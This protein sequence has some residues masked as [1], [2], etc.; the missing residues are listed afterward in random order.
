MK[1]NKKKSKE[2]LVDREIIKGP[3]FRI[4]RRGRFILFESKRTPKEQKK[5]S[6]WL[7]KTHKRL[8]KIIKRKAKKLEKKLSQFNSFD[9]IAHIS[10]INYFADPETYKEYL[11]KGRFCYP[12]YIA[13]LCLKRSFNQGTKFPIE[14]P[15]IES[16][17]KDLKEIFNDTQFYLISSSAD[18]N[19]KGSPTSLELLQFTIRGNELLVRSPAYTHHLHKVLKSLFNPFE[20]ILLKKVGFTIND[21]I[22]LSQAI[23]KL[24]SEKL[25]ERRDHAKEEYD[26]LFDIVKDYRRTRCIP[27]NFDI[28]KV[29][30]K[31][32]AHLS[33]K[34]IKSKLKNLSIAWTLVGL[35]NTYSHSVKELADYSGIDKHRVKSFLELFSLSFRDIERD[36]YIPI[37]VH[38]LKQRPLIKHKD[39]Y[40]CPSPALL[41]WAIKPAF[42][43]ILKNTASNIWNRYI[44]HRHD[45]LLTKSVNLMKSIMP[46][47]IFELNLEYKNK[48]MDISKTNELDALGKFDCILF[49]IEGKAGGFTPPARRGAPD[50]LKKHLKELV[51]KAHYQ[52]LRAKSYIDSTKKPRFRRQSDSSTFKL[53]KDDIKDVFLISLSLEPLGNL[54]GLMHAKSELGVFSGEDLPWIISLYDL[55]VITD[56]IEHP[57]MFPHYVKRRIQTAEQGL[58]MAHDELD[59]FGY[60]LKEGLYLKSQGDIAPTFRMSLTSYTTEFDDYYF[61]ITGLRKTPAPKPCQ[62]MLKEFEQILFTIEKSNAKG[63]IGA[64]MQLLNL[65][66]KTQNQLLNCIKT[67]QKKYK[68]DG[69]IHDVTLGGKE[70][71]GW[72]ITYICGPK[73]ELAR[74]KLQTYCKM[75]K[76][77]LKARKWVGLGEAEDEGPG[78][79]IIVY[80]DPPLGS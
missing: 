59:L 64:A 23:I 24:P 60:Y 61:Y 7:A 66:G 46:D 13:L 20:D 11:H 34:E 63:R 80:L 67:T 35:G 48:E 65:G 49:L 45:Y 47:A 73:I 28:H 50:R 16:I 77:Q 21:A 76:H 55:M 18:P 58:I 15:D 69:E 42:E 19:R 10:F 37:P 75:K 39:R 17:Q 40:L 2:S 29:F 31:K 4:E 6:S 14:G 72:G 41:D 12:E 68:Q 9:I 54:T 1:K 79:N 3:G 8:P 32:L 26:R 27:D 78:I 38:P 56:F 52:A 30:I 5:L 43:K 57:S 25:Y 71:G 53:N 36:F 44:K 62:K 33:D 22:Q 70:E 51:G 74:S